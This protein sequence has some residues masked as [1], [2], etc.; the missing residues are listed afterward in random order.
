MK[1]F[2]RLM[3]EVFFPPH[4]AACDKL[5]VPDP[6][7]PTPA[8]CGTCAP[9]WSREIVKSCSLCMQPFH[10]CR[11][12]LPRMKEQGITAHVK[13]AP[14]CDGDAM[15]VTRRIVLG[16]KDRVDSRAFRFLA[17]E[18]APGVRAA[19]AASDARRA[20]KGLFACQTVITFL[21]RNR[22]TATRVGLDQ[23]RELARAL[24]KE[25]DY[26]FL[27]LLKRVR[28][29]VPQKQLSRKARAENLKGAFAPTRSARGLRV[30]LVDD[31]VTT[32]AGMAEGAGL[33]FAE[34]VI[35][36]SVAFTEKR[37]ISEG[38]F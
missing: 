18:L 11:C 2:L 5:M 3:G 9:L 8:L 32:G 28:D 17:A 1:R 15:S 35:A 4:C 12:V 7:K 29:G 14:Y 13:M 6:D 25:L 26:P 20:S 21:P 27:P 23:A 31:L 22:R 30:L 36:V 38:K 19:V 16:I 37:R 10:E 24:A 33:L 34:E